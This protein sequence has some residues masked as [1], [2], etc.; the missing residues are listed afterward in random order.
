MFSNGHIFFDISILIK[1][2]MMQNK[3]VRNLISPWLSLTHSLTH[4][5]FSVVEMADFC[6]NGGDVQGSNEILGNEF[7]EGI[8][9]VLS[10]A[11]TSIDDYLDVHFHRRT[12]LLKHKHLY[13]VST[14]SLKDDSYP[15]F[16]FNTYT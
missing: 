9:V 5:L 13:C 14:M 16:L 7:I 11:V 3:S 6:G 1:Q 4:S 10:H 8:E 2:S 15:L 12:G